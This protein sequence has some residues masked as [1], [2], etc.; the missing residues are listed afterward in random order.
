MSVHF[1]QLPHPEDT[2]YDLEGAEWCVYFL[3]TPSPAPLVIYLLCML[4][5]GF[6]LRFK[7]VCSSFFHNFYC[8]FSHS[9]KQI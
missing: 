6:Y 9:E 8:P 3:H 4:F 2:A 5:K 1:C 7:D